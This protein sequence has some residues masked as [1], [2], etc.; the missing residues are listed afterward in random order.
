MAYAEHERPALTADTVILR[1]EAGA[2]DVLL[3]RR[4]NPP[5]VGMWALPG[6]FLDAFERPEDAAR[7]ELAEETGLAFT[8]TLA[9]I[10]LY[11]ERGRDPRGWTVSAAYLGILTEGGADVAGGDDA[12]EARWF[13][14]SALPEL[15]FD[16]TGVVSDALAM[17]GG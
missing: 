10:G 7:R 9:L 8:G 16:H 13:A 1:G 14:A 4:G 5:F 6:G 12:A 15:A 11:G 2:R 17:L 3:I